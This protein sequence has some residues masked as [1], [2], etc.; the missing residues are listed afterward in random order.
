MKYTELSDFIDNRMQMQHIYQPVMLLELLSNGGTS[1]DENIAKSILAYD[2]SQIEYYTYR[3]NNMVGRVLR[4]HSVVT[5]DRKTKAFTLIGYE[6]LNNTE[7]ETLK[8]KCQEKLDSYIQKRGISI[9]RHRTQSSGYIS[10]RTRYQVLKRAKFH[11][12]LCGISADKKAL[13]VDHIIPRNKGGSDD[14]SNLQCLC[15]SC[16]SMKGDTDDTDFRVI[17]ESYD[18]RDPSCVFCNPQRDIWLSENELAYAITDKYPVTG[19]HI[20]IIPKRHLSDYFDLGQ[21][22]I[23]ACTSLLQEQQQATKQS[24]DTIDGFNVG[25]N[26]G[27]TAGQTVMHCHIHLIP[28]RQGDVTDSFG[29]IRNIIP[30]KGDYTKM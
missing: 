17:R 14:I 4:D 23:N 20:L 25:I 3:T 10:G 22:E 5:R 13:E 29:G 15:Y 18:N 12:E 11:C 8:K 26:V 28:R 6:T 27:P 24:D 9:F 2:Q 30:G 1:T 21:A 19:G 7:I 16:N